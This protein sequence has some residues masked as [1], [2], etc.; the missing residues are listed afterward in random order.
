MLLRVVICS[1]VVVR[2]RADPLGWKEVGEEIG[3][4]G[5]FMTRS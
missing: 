3:C 5:V 2:E 1:L 4:S